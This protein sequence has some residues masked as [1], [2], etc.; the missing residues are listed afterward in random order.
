MLNA[1]ILS[2]KLIS[3]S[4]SRVQ[5]IL[6]VGCFFYY[7]HMSFSNVNCQIGPNADVLLS[8]QKN[9]TVQSRTTVAKED[10]PSPNVSPKKR[11]TSSE[12]DSEVILFSINCSLTRS[13]KSFEVDKVLKKRRRKVTPVLYSFVLTFHCRTELSIWW[14]GQDMKTVR[15][16]GSE[17]TGWTV[18]NS[19]RSLQ[20]HT[21]S[22]QRRTAT[23]VL[24]IPT[25]QTATLMT[26][27]LK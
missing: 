18:L 7:L 5:S 10:N 1:E 15:T 14:S 3:T 19:W 4:F 13:F 9:I 24:M 23:T 17:R 8:G 20:K 26:T 12:E 16:L 27:L 21:V 22:R 11:K 6:K 2:E 25:V